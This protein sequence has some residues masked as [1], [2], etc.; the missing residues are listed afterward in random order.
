MKT[1][2]DIRLTTTKDLRQGAYIKMI[3]KGKSGKSWEEVQ[4]DEIM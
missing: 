1:K 3:A 2:Q 4:A